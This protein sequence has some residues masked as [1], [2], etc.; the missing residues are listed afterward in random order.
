[1]TEVFKELIEY[2]Q[3]RRE[4]FILNVVGQS[5]DYTEVDEVALYAEIKAFAASFERRIQ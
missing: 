5:E 1:M 4:N 2:L 3:F